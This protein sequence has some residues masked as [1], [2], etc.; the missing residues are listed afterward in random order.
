MRQVSSG[1]LLQPAVPEESLAAASRAVRIPA[2]YGPVPWTGCVTFHPNVLF[3]LYF[4]SFLCFSLL[5][6]S[7]ISSLPLS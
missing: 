2:A 3:F 6:I 5:S 1:G 4:L 7:S